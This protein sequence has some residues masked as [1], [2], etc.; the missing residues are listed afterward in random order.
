MSTATT[1]I[2][3][4]GRDQLSGVVRQTAQRFG[5]D[6]QAM[7]RNVFSLQDALLG[8]GG[9]VAFESMRREFTLYDSAIR[10]M[11]KVTDE[12]MESIRTRVATLPPALGNVTELVKGYYQTI[13]AGV[14]DPNKSLETL[15]ESAKSAKAAHMDQAEVIK[16]VT[17]VMAGYAGEVRTAS[18]AAD[19]L[20]TI[21]R[22]G[23][24]SFQEL[25]PVIGDVAAISHEVAVNQN[26]M[27]AALAAVTQTAGSTSQAAT[28]YRAMLVNLMKPTKEMEK[29]LGALGVSSG[30]A[31][32]EQYGLAGTLGRLQTHAEQSGIG[33]GKLFESSEALLAVAALSRGEFAQYNTNLEVMTEKVGAADKAYQEW[34]ESSQATDDLFRNTMSNTLIKIGEQIMP[35]VNEGVREFAGLVNE[36]SD[37]IAGLFGR[38]ADYGTTIAAAVVPALRD[39]GGVLAETVLPPAVAILETGNALLRL[40]PSEYQSSVGAG[41]IGYALLGPKGAVIASSIAAIDASMDQLSQR[42]WVMMGMS[43]S[44][45]QV[46]DELRA[47]GKA[48]LESLLTGTDA[49]TQAQHTYR[50]AVSHTVR[51]VVQSAAEQTAAVEKHVATSTLLTVGA[52]AWM[53]WGDNAERASEKAKTSA[54]QSEAAIRRMREA[55]AFGEDTLAVFRKGVAEAEAALAVARQKQ[56][57]VDDAIA[58]A[59]EMAKTNEQLARTIKVP[60]FDPKEL[61]SA[62]AAVS[63]A[64]AR[65]R[66]A[67]VLHR[68]AVESQTVATAEVVVGT[69]G[70]VTVD[71]SKEERKR[72]DTVRDA[73]RDI[74]RSVA[75]R[76]EQILRDWRDAYQ[77]STM[78]ETRYR[79]Q[80]LDDQY[81]QYKSVVEDKKALELWYA[82]EVGKIEAARTA[83]QAAQAKARQE[84]A[85]EAAKKSTEVLTR[86][87]EQMLENI[88]NATADAFYTMFTDM[89]SGWKSVWTSMEQWALKTLAQV[90][91]AAIIQPVI[92]PVV[93]GGQSGGVQS[94]LGFGGSSAA[95]GGTLPNVPLV[96]LFGGSG[97]ANSI[98]QWGASMFPSLFGGVTLA[99]AGTP[100]AGLVSSPTAGLA[101]AQAGTQLTSPLVSSGMS[102][103]G[104]LGGLAGVGGG[105]YQMFQGGTGNIVSGAGTAIGG[106]MMFTPAAPFAPLVM[107][108]SQLLGG[109][110]GGKEH[111]PSVI[112]QAQDSTLG[113]F[114]DPLFHTKSG[115]S[116]DQGVQLGKAL[117]EVVAGTHT[118]LASIITGTLGE[119]SDALTDLKNLKFSWG[120]KVSTDFGW[121][122]GSDMD[123]EELWAKATKDITGEILKA[124]D[125]LFASIA[126][127]MAQG[128]WSQV[129]DAV[130]AERRGQIFSTGQQAVAG[131]FS[132]TIKG[133]VEI[134]RAGEHADYAALGEAINEQ[135]VGALQQSMLT[136][137]LN[138]AS[139]ILQQKFVNPLLDTIVGGF[140]DGS[141]DLQSMESAYK[142]LQ[143]LDISDLSA[144]L[145]EIF[146]GI[147]TGQD[148]NWSEFSEKYGQDFSELL[149]EISTQG[150]SQAELAA[151]ATAAQ[152]SILAQIN[153]MSATVEAMRAALSSIAATN[154]ETARL[155]REQHQLSLNAA[156]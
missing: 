47:K 87:N 63:L 37:D 68:K 77:K 125:P 94:L 134:V 30:K 128:L 7:Q 66:E 69:A 81:E 129:R 23:Q 71:L 103:L 127:E 85:E 97:I 49:V 19:L 142:A 95:G 118:A 145:T 155:T 119:D 42:M 55:Q 116:W 56:A 90:A 57:D 82:V 146:T 44:Y 151:R 59:V 96:G 75:E 62:E 33:I 64:Y 73:L 150:D 135:V 109:L 45:A 72:V 61:T 138:Q 8:L 25:I 91:A 65:L 28:Q 121:D 17:K 140:V 32:I 43:G 80:Q 58:R 67:A 78:S 136:V 39:T 122:F 152:E 144:G 83:D 10:D 93:M 113:A 74:E 60:V 31:A 130:I 110:F 9:V 100:L 149:D 84:A 88:Q 148:I 41:I 132:E 139:A 98:N 147:Q 4:A 117:S 126:E 154:A 18:E 20:F 14:T 101:A 13:S 35:S 99:Q 114:S 2:V 51:G 54:E 131:I 3:I 46:Q 5:T 143:G 153:S 111:S 22:Q 34:L 92:A 76:H 120:R 29:A 124:A 53:V 106:A 156:G 26:E 48:A 70:A 105:L 141:F 89:D 24:T 104:A 79:R 112:F 102:F 27:G 107:L 15:T 133:A 108:G 11:G 1:Q 6:L 38:L 52:T 137:G 36:H 12:S 50:A 115:G 16:G 86:E 21:E 123:P 40:V